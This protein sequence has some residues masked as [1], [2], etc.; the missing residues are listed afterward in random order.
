LTAAVT[1]GLGWLVMFPGIDELP[2][3]D[4][5]ASGRL[6]FGGLHDVMESRFAED[7]ELAG[8]YG[9]DEIR[10][11]PFTWSGFEQSL[12]RKQPVLIDF[13]ADYCGT[14][15]VLEAQFLNVPE[16]REVLQDKGVVPLKA[17]LSSRDHAVEAQEMLSDLGA[18][19]VPV[20]AIFS[21]ED[22]YNPITFLDTYTT[23]SLLKAL[24]TVRP[25]GR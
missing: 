13:T 7:L 5:F 25:S 2:G 21:P 8:R 20:L 3:I 4:K 17:N 10:W 24:D 15:K 1:I 22:P 9:G 16:V 18:K 19:Q 11:Q 14:C 12:A 23:E 6:S